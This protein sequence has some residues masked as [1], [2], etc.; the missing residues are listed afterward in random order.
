[1]T[2][3]KYYISEIYAVSYKCIGKWELYGKTNIY[4]EYWYV[5]LDLTNIT[6]VL[7]IVNVSFQNRFLKLPGLVLCG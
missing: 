6:K 1:M 5:K 2:F 7:N 3:Q 4:L